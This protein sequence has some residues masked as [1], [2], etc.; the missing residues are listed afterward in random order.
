MSSPCSEK[1]SS[2]ASAASA[3]KKQMKL[4]YNNLVKN[5]E[6]LVYITKSSKLNTKV[7]MRF[8]V[9]QSSVCYAKKNVVK[10]QK[11]LAK[12]LSKHTTLED[13]KVKSWKR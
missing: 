10:L 12:D 11:S 5:A 2:V 8:G 7:P 1:H 9:L 13:Q 4:V 6:T 3:K